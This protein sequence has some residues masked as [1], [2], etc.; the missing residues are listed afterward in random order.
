MTIKKYIAFPIPTSIA[1]ATATIKI[2]FYPDK[3]LIK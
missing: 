3:T 2:F 1:A